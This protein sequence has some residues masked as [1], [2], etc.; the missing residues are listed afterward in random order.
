MAKLKDGTRIYGNA[1]IDAALT[2]VD[3]TVSGNLTISGTTTTVDT[4]T[5]RIEDPIIEI[6]GGEAGAALITNDNKERGVLLHYYGASS[7]IDAFMGWHTTNGEFAFGSNVTETT[8]NIVVNQ[9]GNV[10]GFHFLGE[11]DTLANI[12][13]ANVTGTVTNANMSAYAGNVTASSQSNITSVGTLTTLIVGNATANTNFGNGTIDA[14][15]NANVGNLYVVTDGNNRGNFTVGGNIYGNFAGEIYAKG[16]NTYVQFND[17]SLVG[18]S[19]G[20]VFNKTSNTL[21]VTGNVS[22]ANLVTAG[23]A[24]VTGT[25]NVG[26]LVTAGTANVTGIANVGNLVSL[27]YANVTGNANVGNLGT[28]GLII[29]AGNL[30]AN[31]VTSN[32]HI[33]SNT[34][35]ATGNIVGNNIYSNTY[36]N[37]ISTANV[38]NLTTGGFV[39][40]TGNVT[41]G[42][43]ISSGYANIDGNVIGGNI[44]SG[45]WANIVGNII[46][47]NLVTSNLAN[48]GNFKIQAG[49]TVTGDLIPATDEGGNLGNSTNAWKSLY[50]SGDT[51][52]LGDQAIQSN[53]LGLITANSLFSSNYVANYNITATNG[54]VAANLGIVSGNFVYVKSLPNTYVAYATTDGNITGLSTFNVDTS[55]S[56]VNAPNVTVSGTV[57]AGHVKDNAISNTQMVFANATNVMTGNSGLTFDDSSGIFSVPN[58]TISGTLVAGHVKD[59]A[60]ANT[61]IV[62]AN[63]TNV[64]TGNAN[65]T[66]DSSTG[67]FK[68]DYIVANGVY[69]TNLL[70]A[71]LVGY[72][73]NATHANYISNGTSNIDTPTASGNITV[74]IG[75]T[76]NTVIFHQNGVVIEGS[77]SANA[78][79]TANGNIITNDIL[80]RTG[81]VTITATQ[82]GNTSI[83]LKPYGTAGVV[84]VNNAKI[85]NLA[86][87][88]ADQD[89]ATKGYVDAN[90]QGLDIKASVRLATT[91]NRALS[92]LTAVDTVTPVDGDRILVRAQTTGSENGIY[93][94]HSAGWTRSVDAVQDEISGGTFTFVEEGSTLQD[95]GWVVS[96]DNPI[97]VDTTSIIWTQFSS[98]GIISVNVALSK[99]GN[100]IN[101]KYDTTTL[102]VN[103]SNELKVTDSAAF[104]TPNIG[105]ATGTSLNLSTG[106]ITSGNANLG[107]L[108][109]SN[110]F[111][112]VLTS[113]NQPNVTQVGTLTHLEVSN[114]AGGGA[115]GTV[116]ANYFKSDN[117]QYANGTAIDFQTAAGSAN[118][119]QFKSDSGNDLN[120]SAN[121]TFDYTTN[122]LVLAG[123]ANISN[124]NVTSNITACIANVSGNVIAGN[125]IDMALQTNAVPF[126]NSSNTLIGSSNLTFDDSTLKVTGTAN[127]TGN[128][129]AGNIVD[130]ALNTNAVPFINSSNTLIGSSNLT[131][132]DSTLKV[133]GTANVT[134]NV[135]AGNIVDLALQTNAVPFIN[136]SNTLIGSSNLTFDDSTLKVTGIA[137]VT[138][139]V[140][141]GNIVDLALSTNRVPYINSSNTLIDSS[142]LTFDGTTLTAAAAN[143]T[144]TL[145]AANFIDTGLTSGRLVYSD[146]GHY[147]TDSSALS[148]NGTTLS[149]NNISLTGNITANYITSAALTS[150]RV[151]YA[152]SSGILQDN[153]NFTFGTGSGP[154]LTV[155]NINAALGNVSAS[156]FIGNGAA[157]T[158][159]TGGNVNGQVGNALVAATVY[160]SAQACI[161]SVGTLTSL[162]VSGVSQFGPVGNVKIT[163]GTDGYW[164]KTD[165]QGNLS[166]AEI[167]QSQL[168]NGTSNVSIPAVNGNI[169]MSVGG[170]ANVVVVTG[171]GANVTGIVDV[172]GNILANNIFANNKIYANAEVVSTSA[173]TGTLL[174]KGGIG[175][176][177]NIYTSKALGF[178]NNNGGT[179]SV[180]YIQ[181]N[182]TSNSLDFIFN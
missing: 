165:G 51:I 84:D 26:N 18:A 110:Y 104:V 176:I 118:Q 177:G 138:G 97:T 41:G 81:N 151:T 38:G 142:N 125:F 121:L 46:G 137:N 98:A 65:L 40:A 160:A 179:D 127:V 57:I 39:T 47:G 67:N 86:D 14:T 89:A 61:Q 156:S 1:Q 93:I 132:D 6:G 12:T 119:I 63:A 178:A 15:G 158:F 173:N 126:I 181:F 31:N 7:A 8:G 168:S 76:P 100:E 37:V 120:A 49:G 112:G 83:Y 87:P 16:S 167:I 101:V 24:N 20:F 166:F 55:G 90:S 172:T 96:T 45:G 73:A 5:T 13:G 116:L 154:T 69:L 149:S 145:T 43:I 75:G 109:T 95:T 36:A 19:A 111:A 23:T 22:G 108:T 59:N 10:H 131:F 50:V 161:T 153:A 115:N 162:T 48:V 124:I 33:S 78:N 85:T 182:S 88:T 122:L 134:G 175:A 30:T 53:S 71:N 141:A 144:T 32:Y 77:I 117:Y 52:Y 136:S 66:F 106:N 103:G 4:T 169:N 27:G 56:I 11:G 148:F 62:F 70:A 94:A 42:N 164:L 114:V 2:V 143:I 107:N 133:T 171:T 28:D 102:A 17:E 99:T 130:L 44:I 170:A 157:I 92:G 129:V 3:I 159:I 68:S 34:I 25:A 146:V 79:I 9:Y 128:I 29:A 123:T 174:V 74:G 152:G 21:T 163:G 113:A 35:G 105:A 54:N 135:V 155:D 180:A 60:I 147:L 64:M 72:I 58:V 91:G 80:S 140:V 82:S 150:S 139:N